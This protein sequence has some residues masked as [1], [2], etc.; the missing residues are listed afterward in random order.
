[1]SDL[2][3]SFIEHNQKRPEIYFS[4]P[5]YDS[6]TGAMRMAI[7]APTFVLS[8]YKTLIWTERDRKPGDFQLT[9]ENENP[10]GIPFNIYRLATSKNEST[11]NYDKVSVGWWVNLPLDLSTTYMIIEKIDVS[12]NEG[13]YTIKIT[14]NSVE[15][16]LSRRI[17]GP[18]YGTTNDHEKPTNGTKYVWSKDPTFVTKY[19]P[20][21]K[22]IGIKLGGGSDTAKQLRTSSAP[23]LHHLWSIFCLC[24]KSSW[25]K[26]TATS[27][28][29]RR[30][31]SEAQN[32]LCKG[33]KY[34][35]EFYKPGQTETA[36][37]VWSTGLNPEI[38][39]D[40][41][42]RYSGGDA[43]YNP[44]HNWYVPAATFDKKYNLINNYQF[45][46]KATFY[47]GC[48]KTRY[49][50]CEG[51]KQSFRD[52]PELNLSSAGFY[53]FGRGTS[54]LDKKVYG[55][56]NRAYYAPS[57]TKSK[58]SLIASN[59]TCTNIKGKTFL[60]YLQSLVATFDAT[61][62]IYPDPSC[63]VDNSAPNGID[64]WFLEVMP[65][66]DRSQKQKLQ[67]ATN[68]SGTTR[69]LC[70]PVVFSITNNTLSNC[71]YS[72]DASKY[73]NSAVVAGHIAENAKAGWLEYCTYNSKN[74]DG[75]KG[76]DRREKY[77]DK[78]ST[79]QT[80]YGYGFKF[81][82]QLYDSAGFG[83]CASIQ[84]DLIDTN[85]A[86]WGYVHTS[87]TKQ[88]SYNAGQQGTNNPTFS[89]ETIDSY[90][91]EFVIKDTTSSDSTFT[92]IWNYV[93]NNQGTKGLAITFIPSW[94]LKKQKNKQKGYAWAM[95]TTVS[96]K[97]IKWIKTKR[98][99]TLFC[100][101]DDTVKGQGWY[102]NNDFLGCTTTVRPPTGS[103]VKEWFQSKGCSNTNW[104]DSN[105][106][107]E[108]A[109][110]GTRTSFNIYMKLFLQRWNGVKDSSNQGRGDNEYIAL[111]IARSSKAIWNYN[112]VVSYFKAH[113]WI[114]NAGTGSDALNEPAS[115]CN[116][117]SILRANKKGIYSKA[118]QNIK[119]IKI[120][121][122][123]GAN[124]SIGQTS[125]GGSTISR[126]KY[127]G[128]VAKVTDNSNNDY[129]L[130]KDFR[131]T[132][133]KTANYWS[134]WKDF[135]KNE[136]ENYVFYSVQSKSSGSGS[137]NN[138]PYKT[139]VMAVDY[140]TDSKMYMAYGDEGSTSDFTTRNRYNE[141]LDY[142]GMTEL[143][144]SDN[145]WNLAIKAEVNKQNPVYEY[146][147][148][149]NLGDY[150]S[151]L[152]PFVGG[153]GQKARVSEFIRSW[154]SEGYKEYPTFV[155]E[156]NSLYL[157]IDNE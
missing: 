16:I 114:V 146:K 61:F 77:I 29:R 3:S 73:K 78:T 30:L 94:D 68:M 138:D 108:N 125:P 75:F 31:T 87:H 151:V 22:D 102:S 55:T 117:G 63:I 69:A 11:A 41:I 47:D 129:Y 155:M 10:E 118:T 2:S 90:Y 99:G 115:T 124:I 57:C 56:A 101:R 19:C 52:I 65:C 95:T 25:T 5:K 106:D 140:E 133:S 100:I 105:N 32:N 97:E 144:K 70:T 148:D 112:S 51:A 83:G 28:K 53:A 143:N 86:P 35:G 26:E 43:N 88:Y 67:T 60:E 54:D 93:N 24:F 136:K 79:K 36:A 44:D 127:Y 66:R 116:S 21:H 157:D 103:Q 153:M 96:G 122:S 109:Y 42:A 152:T 6:K 49:W 50:A 27:S 12:W 45:S 119:S 110:I 139:K 98:S 84:F 72:F 135:T 147:K 81:K 121:Y 62:R 142:E 111:N 91:P 128:F 145:C 34:W 76:L 1:M 132:G 104:L 137:G 113:G 38:L 85:P 141:Y 7:N 156:T 33:G 130:T 126:G 46:S 82:R 149:Y 134:K 4:R 120:W 8:E 18:G 9:I 71:S 14:G 92:K 37:G 40:P 154:D 48:G 89:E 39:Y 20:D 58:A 15:S 59:I 150:V 23:I 17:I 107:I 80:D 64:S 74:T 123:N 13:I 131:T